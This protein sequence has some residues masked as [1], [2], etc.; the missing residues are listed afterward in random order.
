VGGVLIGGLIGAILIRAAVW[1]TNKIV[2]GTVPD[3]SFGK[4][5]GMAV[6]AIVANWVVGF[7]AGLAMRGGDPQTVQIVSLL[8]GLPISFFVLAGIATA[9][10]P[11]TFPRACLVALFYI[12]VAM[13]IALVIGV[14]FFVVLGG[15]AALR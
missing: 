15:F 5:F 6:A 8:A 7:V 12:L 4:A 9:M 3:P 14:L 2:G 13:A 1:L 11:T 10:L